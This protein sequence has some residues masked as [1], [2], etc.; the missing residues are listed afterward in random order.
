[1]TDPNFRRAVVFMLDHNEQGAFGLVINNP[2]ATPA[3]EVLDPLGLSWSGGDEK[4]LRALVD[5]LAT[6]QLRLDNFE[7]ARRNAEFVDIEL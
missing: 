7:K 1:M 4:I 2:I 5:S 6:A 3:S